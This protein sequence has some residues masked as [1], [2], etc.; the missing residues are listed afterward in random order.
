VGHVVH[1][2]QRRSAL[3]ILVRKPEG[4]RP[5]RIQRRRSEDNIKANVEDTRCEI[6]DK[7]QL[8]RDRV[9][10]RTLVNTV[11]DLRIPQKKGFFFFYQMRGDHFLENCC[12]EL[13]S[14]LSNCWCLCILLT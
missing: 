6:M 4:K 3:E 13:A 7:I 9:Q 5:F 14:C 11:M 1:M 10:W 8:A 12:V 2:G